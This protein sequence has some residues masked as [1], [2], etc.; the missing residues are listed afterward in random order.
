MPPKLTFVLFF[1]VL[2]LVGTIAAQTLGVIDNR[3]WLL[4]PVYGVLFAL[5]GMRRASSP[6]AGFLWGGGYALLLWLLL[7]A[8]LL[9]LIDAGTVMGSVNAGRARFAELVAYLVCFGLPMG[10]ALGVL[11]P[12]LNFPVA[13][14][15]THWPRALFVGGLAGIVGGWAF[16]RWMEQVDFFPLVANLVNADTRETGVVVHY[17]IAVFIGASFGALFQHDVRGHGSGMGWGLAYGMLWWFIGPLTLLP[18]LLGG[19][20]DWR[21]DRASA[22]FGSMVG[23][24]I[25]GL[26][27]GLV[28]ATLDKLWVAFFHETDPI[29]REVEGPGARSLGSLG[30][31][32][33]A[34]IAG[35]LAF[36]IVMYATGALPVVASLFGGST[37]LIGFIGHLVISA[38][39][40]MTFGLLF[41]YE[42]PAAGHGIAW[43]L[44][45]GLIWWFVGRLTLLPL[46]LGQPLAWSATEAAAALPSLVGHLLYSAATAALFYVLERRHRDWLVLDPR[47]AAR[48]ARRT[49]PQGTPAPATWMLALG[50]GTLLPVM[51]GM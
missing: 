31:G 50:L 4:G 46:L 2:G 39:I 40:G 41:Q 7:P 25:Y 26:I 47:Y 18:L 28:Y 34:S 13:G 49:R 43:G 23:H 14:R 15:A 37:A 38:A 11:A 42:A 48:L 44:V 5:I 24:A 32:A 27:A 12:R 6:G 8:G 1:A 35:G 22:L 9:S 20:V 36:S 21:A 51:L 10:L 33:L 45:Y 17:L 29:N 3:L 16:G 19:P 30:R